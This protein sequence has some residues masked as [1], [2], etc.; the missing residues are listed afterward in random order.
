M[1]INYNSFIGKSID[2]KIT[3]K[4]ILLTMV[5]STLRNIEILGLAFHDPIFPHLN[6]AWPPDWIL[7]HVHGPFYSI[8]IHVLLSVPSVS[9]LLPL[10]HLV[11]K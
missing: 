4:Y 1:D 5:F 6:V 7:L 8:L 9:C 10:F 2:P 11:P 3:L